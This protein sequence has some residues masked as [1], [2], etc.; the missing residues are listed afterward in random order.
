MFSCLSNFFFPLENPDDFVE[1]GNENRNFGYDDDDELA[2]AIQ[3]SLRESGGDVVAP[4]V[5]LRTQQDHAYLEG[6]M[7]DRRKE[8]RRLED[9]RRARE[10]EEAREL[11]N[12]IQMSLVEDTERSLKELEAEI[13]QEPL[14]TDEGACR[15][16]IR[17]PSGARLQRCLRSSDT[18]GTLRKWIKVQRLY[19]GDA[20]PLKF[21][22]VMDYPR[23]EFHDDSVTLKDAGM[24]PRAAIIVHSLEDE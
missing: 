5:D 11:E 21:S 23:R 20:V 7:E 24:F 19:V 1:P 10:S 12:A 3:A 9:E 6:L 4:P 13:P 16:A 14:D 17:L 15:L 8:E 22:I 2:R 18:I